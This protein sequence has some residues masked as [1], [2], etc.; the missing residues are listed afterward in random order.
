M[1]FSSSLKALFRNWIKE[2]DGN[3]AVE[4]IFMIPLLFW[5]Y[6]GTHAYFDVYKHEG[7]SFKANITI[8]DMISREEN[9]VNDNY[10]DGAQ[11][12]LEFL[13][14]VDDTPQ[15][16]I[17]TFRW[18]EADNKYEVVWSKT[19]GGK[20]ELDNSGLDAQKDRLPVMSDFDVAIL[21]ETWMDYER[22]FEIPLADGLYVD[23]YT[24][25]AFT[26]TSPRFTT[27]LCF[28][29]GADLEC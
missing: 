25:E 9:P 16:R 4:S 29:T 15:L 10:I 8:A 12:L 24:L 7:V 26:V 23:S 21:V 20:P 17:T 22:P 27:Q 2:E 5:A 1:M 6:L 18:L 28:D 13:S 19:R 3:V 14:N 11:G